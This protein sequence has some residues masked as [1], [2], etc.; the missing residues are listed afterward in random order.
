[1]CKQEPLWISKDHAE[2]EEIKSKSAEH[3][4]E[5]RRRGDQCPT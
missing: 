3:E 5:E 2:I 1:M 4:E